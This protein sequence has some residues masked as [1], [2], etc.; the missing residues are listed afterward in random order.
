MNEVE[1]LLKSTHN[2]AHAGGHGS[3]QK[4][5]TCPT[6]F[7]KKKRLDFNKCVEFGY[8]GASI[9]I[10]KQNGITVCLNEKV[11]TFLTSIHWMKNRTNLA[12]INASKVGPCKDMSRKNKYVIE[13]NIS[14]FQKVVQKKCI[15]SIVRRSS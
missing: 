12:A 4:M 2:K 1:F 5:K 14:V 11:N 10:G 15:A 8:D 6:S 9:M 13:F 7:L 3:I